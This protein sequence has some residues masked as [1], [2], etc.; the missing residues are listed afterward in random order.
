MVT[1]V[2]KSIDEQIIDFQK[3]ID[4]TQS[5]L[6]TLTNAKYIECLYDSDFVE[7]KR[8]HIELVNIH[9]KY[10]NKLQIR[11]SELLNELKN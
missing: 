2:K 4:S 11:Y 1:T 3:A 7:H 8:T 6:E 5:T 10:L 9:L